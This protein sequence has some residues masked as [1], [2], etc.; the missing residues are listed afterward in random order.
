MFVQLRYGVGIDSAIV[1]TGWQG[2]TPINVMP[3]VIGGHI[4]T[5]LISDIVSD[6][7]HFA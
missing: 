3:D 5:I 6:V 7:L 2:A 1:A 4:R